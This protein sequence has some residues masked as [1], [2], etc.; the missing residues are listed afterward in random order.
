MAHIKLAESWEIKGKLVERANFNTL[1]K[2]MLLERGGDMVL[3]A[4]YEN[5]SFDSI[6]SSSFPKQP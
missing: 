6:A 2:E 1:L 4:I 3:Q 5:P